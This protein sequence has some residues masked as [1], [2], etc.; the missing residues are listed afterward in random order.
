MITL[1]DI[2]AAQGIGLELWN[3]YLDQVSR[4]LF[5]PDPDAFQQLRSTLGHNDKAINAALWS[6]SCKKKLYLTKKRMCS[7]L[8]EPNLTYTSLFPDPE[9][10]HVE[11]VKDIKTDTLD[12]FDL[13]PVDFIKIDTQG[14]EL[15]IL[16]G[17]VK[18][19]DSCLGIEL[20]VEFVEIYKNQPLFDKVLSFMLS[21][22]FEFFDFVVEY[23]YNR[24]TLNRTGQLAFADALFL[25]T[26][27]Y[28]SVKCN[29]RQKSAYKTICQ[30]YGKDDLI[31]SVV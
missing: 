2:G 16:Q 5:E 23:R 14:S 4:I 20:E 28:V 31:H 30:I 27:E 13:S 25:R 10:W 8:Y 19:L 9:R 17:G 11:E 7:S 18:T 26:P 3:A 29:E 22:N 6:S 21:K 1:L 15:D 24:E 12:S